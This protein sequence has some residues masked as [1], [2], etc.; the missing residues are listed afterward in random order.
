[1]VIID[2]QWVSIKSLALCELPDRSERDV[3]P[4]LK[5]A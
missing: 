4:S 3:I 5:V 1:M 2:H